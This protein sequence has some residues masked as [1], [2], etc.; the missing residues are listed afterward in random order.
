MLGTCINVQVVDE[1]V[2]KTGLGQ[3]A[4]H[5][6]TDEFGRPGCEDLAGR[7]EALAT[8]IAGVA[9]VN[10]VG[11]LLAGKTDLFGVDDDHVVTT[12]HMRGEAGLVLAT[13][14]QGNAGSQATEHE[15]GCI[16]DEPLFVHS[17]FVQRNCFVAKC[18]H[19]LDY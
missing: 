11:H 18:V 9:G 15:V 12:V 2:T 8:G 5:R 16:N 7:G 14:H 1:L 4:L 19:C 6:P 13:K 10:A 3:H 17:C